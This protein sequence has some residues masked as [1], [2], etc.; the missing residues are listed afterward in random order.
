MPPVKQPPKPKDSKTADEF[1]LFIV[2]LEEIN[3]WY[4]GATYSGREMG[5][6]VMCELIQSNVAHAARLA[7]EGKRWVAPTTLP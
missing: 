1:G 2:N 5:H 3:R 4:R 6:V 7:R